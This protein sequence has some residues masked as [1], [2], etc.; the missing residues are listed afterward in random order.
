MLKGINFLQ[1][2][3]FAMGTIYAPAYIVIFMGRF[4]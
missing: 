2:K 3:G 1:I 4:E